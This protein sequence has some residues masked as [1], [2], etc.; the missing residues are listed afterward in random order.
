LALTIFL[1]L[2]TW[3][4]SVVPDPIACRESLKHV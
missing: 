1:A 3:A 2:A 4:A